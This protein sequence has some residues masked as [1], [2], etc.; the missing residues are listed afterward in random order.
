MASEVVPISQSLKDKIEKHVTKAVR[1]Q[2]VVYRGESAASGLWDTEPPELE[3]PVPIDG[4]KP[5]ALMVDGGVSDTGSYTPTSQQLSIATKIIKFAQKRGY[6]A[7]KVPGMPLLIARRMG[8]TKEDNPMQCVGLMYH[9]NNTPRG[10]HPF[11]FKT[12]PT[13]TLDEL[14]PE[15]LKVLESSNIMPGLIWVDEKSLVVPLRQVLLKANEAVCFPE[16]VEVEWYPPP[17][18]EEQAYHNRF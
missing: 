15:V 14:L 12:W 1:E 6:K 11:R 3:K 2:T 4:Q 7:N 8:Y 5:T 18:E 16:K 9:I 13:Y 10:I 17:S